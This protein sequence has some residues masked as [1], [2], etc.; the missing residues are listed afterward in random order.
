[1]VTVAV[2]EPAAALT[3]P[4][5]ADAV[6]DNV[7][8]AAGLEAPSDFLSLEQPLSPVTRIAALPATASTSRIICCLPTLLRAPRWVTRIQY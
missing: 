2:P 8:V 4:A 5:D 1:M 7:A 6:A 3:P